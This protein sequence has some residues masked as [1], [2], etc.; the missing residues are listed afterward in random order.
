MNIQSRVQNHQK[1]NQPELFSELSS[2]IRSMQ[3]TN[4]RDEW[5]A[6]RPEPQYKPIFQVIE[7]ENLSIFI[8]CHLHLRDDKHFRK[9]KQVAGNTRWQK[10]LHHS[11]KCSKQNTIPFHLNSYHVCCSFSLRDPER[12]AKSDIQFAMMYI[13]DQK[14]I[15]SCLLSS[16]TTRVESVKVSV[17]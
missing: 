10:F 15:F 3:F 13:F 2:K 7:T 17:W 12:I 11:F 8:N 9:L 6:A 14:R 4:E 16:Q 5:Y 1:Q